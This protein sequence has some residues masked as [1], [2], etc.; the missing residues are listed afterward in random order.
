MTLRSRALVVLAESVVQ[1]HAV[2]LNVDLFGR[3]SIRLDVVKPTTTKH[4]KDRDSLQYDPTSPTL[5]TSVRVGADRVLLSRSVRDL[6]IF[7][8]NDVTMRSHV[9]KKTISGCFAVL[10]QLRSIRR[11]LPIPCFGRC[12]GA[13]NAPPKLYGNATLAGLR[14]STVDYYRFP[15]LQPSE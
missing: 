7:I 5:S 3:S 9:T 4:I 14:S 15:M 13:G 6:G 1:L 12:R 8:D 10:R 2:Y 11:S